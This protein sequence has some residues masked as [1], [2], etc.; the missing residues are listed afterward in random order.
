MAQLIKWKPSTIAWKGCSAHEVGLQ[1]MWCRERS[2]QQ[3]PAIFMDGSKSLGQEEL[4]KKVEPE[5]PHCRSAEEWKEANQRAQYL[6]EM[7]LFKLKINCNTDLLQHQEG[8]QGWMWC[9]KTQ[10][11]S[12]GKIQNLSQFLRKW[13]MRNLCKMR[14]RWGPFQQFGPNEDQ[15]LYAA[16]VF[17]GASVKLRVAEFWGCSQKANMLKLSRN[18]INAKFQTLFKRSS[19]EWKVLLRKKHCFVFSNNWLSHNF[20]A[21]KEYGK[22]FFCALSSFEESRP[23]SVPIL[24]RT[25]G[26]QTYSQAGW[27]E[28]SGLWKTL[29]I[30]GGPNSQKGP[31]KDLGPLQGIHL[32]EISLNSRQIECRDEIM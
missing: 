24:F 5:E 23:P 4:R 12:P 21:N 25:A 28:K 10:K 20:N 17:K 7:F 6:K 8:W 19:L 30:K 31:Q 27:L 2:H 29:N 16:T 13:K 14:T 26:I 11:P 1:R 32:S 3:C 18:W 15:D 22:L 9:W